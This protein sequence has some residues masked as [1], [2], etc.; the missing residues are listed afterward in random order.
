M[1]SRH[2]AVSGWGVGSIKGQ[3]IL[4]ALLIMLVDALCVIVS[5]GISLLARFDFSVDAILREY[6][7]AWYRFLPLQVCVTVA[8]FWLLHMYHFVWRSV[9]ARDVAHM[10]ASTVAAYL[11]FLFISVM[12]G[13]HQPRSV[14][15]IMLLCQLVLL[16]GSRCLLRFYS[17]MVQAVLR[18][19][20]GGE[21]VMLIGA[22]LYRL[23]ILQG[24]RSR[25]F[26]ARM[27]LI[28][29]ACPRNPQQPP[30]RAHLLR[31]G[32]QPR[33]VGQVP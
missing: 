19:A 11:A 10:I 28:A 1:A 24:G 17:V 18:P 14:W 29:Y 9:S 12:L 30:R 26:Y 13:N 7:E 8:V 22:A 21:R 27:T 5:G 2:F 15:F 3:S 25:A 6:L 16:G 33:Q 32:R 20:G 23:G 4:R 31:C